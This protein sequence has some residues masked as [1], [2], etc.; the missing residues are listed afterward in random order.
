MSALCNDIYS[1]TL[2][3]ADLCGADTT[4]LLSNYIGCTDSTMFN[5]DPL[6]LF[7]DGS[8]I[9]SVFGCIDS[10]AFNFNPLANT[11]DGSCIPTIFGV[12]GF[13]SY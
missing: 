5:Y 11:D 7:D 12:Y 6:A 9:M 2:I 1:L 8:C 3:D 4:I 13:N 10:T